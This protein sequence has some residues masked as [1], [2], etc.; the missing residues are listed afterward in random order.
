MSLNNLNE[1]AVAIA[2]EVTKAVNNV[3]LG[4]NYVLAFSADNTD[5]NFGAT[6][7]ASKLLSEKV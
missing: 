5:T 4:F 7:S 6:K 2:C 1:T 3:K